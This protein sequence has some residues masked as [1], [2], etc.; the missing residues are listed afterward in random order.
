MERT[1]VTLWSQPMADVRVPFRDFGHLPVA[2]KSHK[3]L[4][5]LVLPERIELS[6]SPLPRE[7]STTELRQR[8]VLRFSPS[9]SRKQIHETPAVGKASGLLR[10]GTAT[11]A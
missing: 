1:S 11:A 8:P 4:K 9:G 2:D 10:A 7:C 3:C 6:T 5:K